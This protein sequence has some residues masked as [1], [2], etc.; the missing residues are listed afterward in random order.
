MKYLKIF[1]C[2]AAFAL[3][4]SVYSS[5]SGLVA[6]ADDPPADSCAVR[7]SVRTIQ[8]SEPLQ[9]EVAEATARL[10]ET[11]SAGTERTVQIDDSIRDGNF[12]LLST[13]EEIITLKTRDSLQL[14]NGHSLTFRPMY[15]DSKKVGLWLNW[16]DHDDSEILNTR[17]HFDAADSVLT[18]TDCGHDKGLILAIRA[19]A[20]SR[21]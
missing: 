10:P 18:G 17:V 4:I 16:R 13:K 2:G 21:Q 9:G 15:L 19:S 1:L 14:P 7:L 11:S 5:P 12:Q 8:A 3:F 20:A 6:R